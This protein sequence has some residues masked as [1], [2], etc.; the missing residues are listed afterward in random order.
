[1][2]NRKLKV[3]PGFYDYQY[4]AERRRHE[5]HKTP[6]A[7]PFILLKGY[8]LEKANFLIDKPIKVEVRENKLVLTVEAT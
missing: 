8:W 6:P 7:V 1:M 2:K 4:S 3:R 5:P